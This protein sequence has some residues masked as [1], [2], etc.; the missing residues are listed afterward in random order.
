MSSPRYLLYR[1]DLGLTS[2]TYLAERATTTRLKPLVISAGSKYGYATN[3]VHLGDSR[4]G[5]GLTKMPPTT[6]LHSV[7][8]QRPPSCPYH[9]DMERDIPQCG[10]KNGRRRKQGKGWRGSAPTATGY[11]V[12]VRSY[13][14]LTALVLSVSSPRIVRDSTPGPEIAATWIVS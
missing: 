11:A 5:T 2:G 1:V 10:S 4:A 14:P 12:L 6:G 7:S 13:V 9:A 3:T 8:H